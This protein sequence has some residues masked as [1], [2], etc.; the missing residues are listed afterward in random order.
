VLLAAAMP[1][2]SAAAQ[3]A[4][5]LPAQP[6][7]MPVWIPTAS[8]LE[9]GDQ[10][11]RLL[12]TSG[13]VPSDVDILLDQVKVRAT[14]GQ[15]FLL[16]C[17]FFDAALTTGAYPER[18]QL[19]RRP[20]GVMA[21]E[22]AVPVAVPPQGS[23]APAV[24][25]SRL[26]AQ[27]RP[28]AEMIRRTRTLPGGIWVQGRRLRPAEFLGAM[29]TLLQQLR[30][31][32]VAPD[33]VAARAYQPPPEWA[34]AAAA[35]PN[36]GA[37]AAA[38]LPVGPAAPEQPSEETPAPAEPPSLRLIP[39]KDQEVSGLTPVTAIYR[40]PTAFLRLIIDGKVAAASNVSPFTYVWDT[41]LAAEGPHEVVAEAI[42]GGKAI[43]RAGITLTAQN[44]GPAL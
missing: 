34:Q 32:G 30:Y 6:A 40:G 39:P 15:C 22:A 17:D 2:S 28:A 5:P 19:E 36:G 20:I 3:G 1:A 29:A 37:D 41:R 4:T 18:T 14:A 43:A 10:M 35:P 8:V 44:G 24:Q 16:F 13:R 23:E 27:C 38:V 12:A 42:S 9:M 25:T 33:L 21:A 31:F 7:E 11:A 26:L